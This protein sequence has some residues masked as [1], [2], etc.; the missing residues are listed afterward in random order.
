MIE[1]LYRNHVEEIKRFL[2]LHHPGAYK[3]YNLCSEKMYDPSLLEG[4]CATF[5]FDDHN[6]PPFPLIEAFCRS[7]EAWIQS[8]QVRSHHSA[9]SRAACHES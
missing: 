3:V 1:G 4:A 9:A 2:Q 8:G 6:C 5:P 7:A